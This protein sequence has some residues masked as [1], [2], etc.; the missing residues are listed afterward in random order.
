MFLLGLPPGGP[1]F[2]EILLPRLSREAHLRPDESSETPGEHRNEHLF[3]E[4]PRSHTSGGPRSNT[5]RFGPLFFDLP[6]KG[7]QPTI[8]TCWFPSA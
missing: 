7:R 4:I 2:Y 5:L 8:T 6:E 3:Q 1:G